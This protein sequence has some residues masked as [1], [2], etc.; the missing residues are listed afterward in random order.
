MNAPAPSPNLI[1]V[2]QAN[3]SFDIPLVEE[4]Y[5]FADESRASVLQFITD[6]QKYHRRRN[7]SHRERFGAPDPAS[8][9]V[10][11]DLADAL[12]RAKQLIQQ[13][14]QSSVPLILESSI[15]FRLSPE[16]RG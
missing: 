9:R 1:D 8:E 13:A 14:Q 11:D 6:L 3:Q 16:P 7:F 5:P 12:E 15:N 10:I 4:T 2:H